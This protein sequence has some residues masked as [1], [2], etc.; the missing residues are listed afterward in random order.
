MC[1][2]LLIEDNEL[3]RDMLTKRLRRRGYQVELAAD[4]RQGVELARRERPDL[5]L[6]DLSLPEI[7]GWQAARILKS[8]AATRG[9]PVVAL[10]AH[11]MLG[12]MEKA[13]EAG[14]DDYATKPVDL[15]LLLGI[16]ERLTGQDT[17]SAA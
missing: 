12:D 11:A 17:P 1:R 9:I 7:D 16:I 3:N 8:D 14:C 6:M 4:G 10:T 13:L 15:P 2:I 5:V